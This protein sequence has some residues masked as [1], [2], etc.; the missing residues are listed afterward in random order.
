[1]VLSALRE[2]VRCGSGICWQKL[3]PP[4]NQLNRVRTFADRTSGA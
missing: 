1:M 3:S 4:K 2:G